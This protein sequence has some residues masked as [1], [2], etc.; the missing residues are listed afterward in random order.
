MIPGINTRFRQIREAL[1]KTQT[2]FASIMGLSRSG[3]T[4]IESGQRSVTD[5]H[6]KLLCAESIDGKFVSEEYLRTGEGTMFKEFPEEEETATI[7]SGLLEDGKNNPFYEIILEIMR[8]YNELSPKS[9]E[10]LRDASAKLL[11][12]LQK[13]KGD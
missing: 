2:E 10:V 3:V 1:N 13:K 7:V 6:I 8:T 4:A 12:N 9:Q 11:E 5:K